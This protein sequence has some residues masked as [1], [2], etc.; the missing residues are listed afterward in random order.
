M[1]EN[2]DVLPQ[3][4]H[5][6]PLLIATESG[7][8]F[9]IAALVLLLLLGYRAIRTSIAASAL[10]VGLGV[11]MFLDKFTYGSPNGLVMFAIWLGVLD[12]LWVHRRAADAGEASGTD[13][14]E[15]SAIPVSDDL[16]S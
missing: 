8:V 13:V 11:W 4:V 16:D 10:M 12:W 5:N 3:V 9:G 1:E 7:V 6:V 14:I 2:P 15:T